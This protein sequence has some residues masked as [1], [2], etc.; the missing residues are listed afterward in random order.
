MLCSVLRELLLYASG[1]PKASYEGNELNSEA[2]QEGLKVLG[3]GLFQD[4][5]KGT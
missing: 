2:K 3:K 1:L 4:K 5:D